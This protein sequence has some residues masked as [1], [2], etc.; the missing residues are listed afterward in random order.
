MTKVLVAMA[1]LLSGT[2][3]AADSS[4]GSPITFHKGACEEHWSATKADVS[5]ATSRW[6]RRPNAMGAQTDAGIH[7]QV[8]DHSKVSNGRF[9]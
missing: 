3:L 4:S 9:A 8:G 7:G 5:F 1:M 6:T 2:L